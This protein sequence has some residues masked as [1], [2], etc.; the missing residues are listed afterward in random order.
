LNMGLVL[1]INSERNTRDRAEES[2]LRWKPK[3]YSVKMISRAGRALES[4]NFDLPEVVIINCNDPSMSFRDLVEE[5]KKD[6]WLHSFGII[7]LY[8][9]ET[10]DEREIAEVFGRLNLLVLLDKSRVTS[11]LAKSVSIILEN[12]QLIFQ[13]E[14]STHLSDVSSGSFEL[15]NDVLAVPI[16]AGIAV[17]N[18]VQQ[19]SFNPEQKYN[20]QLALAELL[21]NGIEHGN[22]GISYDEKNEKLSAGLS[23]VDIINEKCLDPGIAARRVHFE[24][25]NRYSASSF[26]IRDEGEGFDVRKIRQ[27]VD[28]QDR[29]R[30]HGRG[31]KMAEMFSRSLEY[32]EKGNRVTL[33]VDHE[34]SSQQD[35]PEGFARDE[36]IYPQP[37]DVVIQEGERSDSLYYISSGHFSVLHNG[38]KVGVLSSA[39]VFMGEMSFLLNHRRSAGVVADDSGKL[40]RI[41]RKSFVQ[42]MKNY[43]HYGI[44]LSKLLAQKLARSNIQLTSLSS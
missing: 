11:H 21:I 23:V 4:L 31:I 44:F 25:E 16:Y 14:L 22:C 29:M 38:K 35:T 15:E 33:T 32:N 19:G 30:P 2:F 6:A 40:I 39:D 20:L 41:S 8:D 24:W 5:V 1:L 7:G 26:I 12:K 37:G 28:T 18:L 27:D 10:Q 42:A 13:R 43:P 17:T 34:K 36:V 9:S 3:G